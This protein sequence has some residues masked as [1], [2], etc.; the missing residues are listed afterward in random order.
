MD[1]SKSF[2]LNPNIRVITNHITNY[3][4]ISLLLLFVKVLVLF[5][6]ISFLKGN[7]WTTRDLSGLRMDHDIHSAFDDKNRRP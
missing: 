7:K 5:N 1:L 2:I 3:R 6:H 4:P